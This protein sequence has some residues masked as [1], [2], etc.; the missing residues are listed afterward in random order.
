[1]KHSD[2]RAKQPNGVYAILSADRAD[3]SRFRR[4]LSHSFSEKAMREQQPVI[5]S[6]VNLLINRL[7]EHSS[8]GSQDMVSW[9]NVSSRKL[10]DYTIG[11]PYT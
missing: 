9:F 2:G 10:E 6:Y 4:L 3:H 8:Q 7:R 5:T 11:L 1:M